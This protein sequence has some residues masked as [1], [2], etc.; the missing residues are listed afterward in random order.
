LCITALRSWSDGCGECLGRSSS[1][2]PDPVTRSG[3]SWYACAL[4]GWS[5]AHT[6]K[7]ST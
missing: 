1:W 6:A 4:S 2:G 5:E 7:P 3:W